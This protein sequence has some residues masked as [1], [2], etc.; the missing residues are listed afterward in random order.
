M[1]T[2]TDETTQTN[3]SGEQIDD[4]ERSHAEGLQG[5]AI[6]L[7]EVGADPDVAEGDE[8]AEVYER[9]VEEGYI[10]PEGAQ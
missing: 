2:N 10:Q 6:V 4:L 7:W 8:F 1:S 9:C 3:L 5:C